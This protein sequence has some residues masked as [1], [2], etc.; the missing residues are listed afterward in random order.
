MFGDSYISEKKGVIASHLNTK[1]GLDVSGLTN[2]EIYSETCL[3]SIVSIK[4]WNEKLSMTAEVSSG[5]VSYL[6][7]IISNLNQ[8]VI[9]GIIGLEVPSYTML[10]RSLE[11]ILIF[12]YYKDHPIEF[13]LRDNSDKVKKIQMDTL[14]EYI[15]D[16][17]FEMQ[18]PEYDS[19]KIKVLVGKVISLHSKDYAVLS[20]YVHSK[21]QKY[22][23]LNNYLDDLKPNDIVLEKLTYFIV[24]LSTIVNILNIVFFFKV[25]KNFQDSQ[26]EIIRLS[27]SNDGHFKRSLLDIFGEF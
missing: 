6:N 11:N 8:V 14:K 17:P 4:I 13:F 10:R 22:L 24:N 2:F 12:L 15:K 26:K 23:E 3:K 16:Y 20:N 9:M 7:E 19:I 27:I 5:P 25:Y 18:L 21:N 1:F